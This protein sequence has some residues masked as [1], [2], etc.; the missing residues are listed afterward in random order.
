MFNKFRKSL[1]LRSIVILCTILSSIL[2][3]ITVTNIVHQ[4][5]TLWNRKINEAE[6]VSNV[7]LTA[8]RHPML[9]GDQDI[10]QLQFDNYKNLKEVEKIYL[11]DGYGVVKRSTDRHVLGTRFADRKTASALGGQPSFG[12]EKRKTGGEEFFSRIVPIANEQKCYGCHGKE[13]KVLGALGIEFDW[14]PVLR[15]AR[16]TRNDN[17]VLSLLGLF[18]MTVLTLLFLLKVIIQPIKKLEM[19]MIRVSQ[20]NFAQKIETAS[21]DEIGTLTRLFNRMAGD[22][23][24]FM[25]KEKYLI[26]A[27]QQ[28][29][30]ELARVNDNL[31]AEAKERKLVEEKLRT[32]SRQLL[33]IIDFLPDPTLVVNRERVVIAWNRA[34]EKFTDICKEDM[35]GKGKYYYAV[36]FYGEKR[37]MLVDLLFDDDKTVESKYD[38]FERKGNTLYAETT[39]PMLNAGKGLY[40]WI[41]ASSLFDSNGDFAGAVE[42]VRDISERKQAEEKLREAM[43]TKSKFISVVS[44]E[45]RTPLTSI[46]EGI[47]IVLDGSAGEV[48]DEQKD[49]LATAKRNVDRLARLINDVL[50]FQ[51]LESGKGQFT[52]QENALNDVVNEVYQSMSPAVKAK[53]L[54]FFITCDQTAGKLRFDRDKIIQVLTNLVNNAMKFTE[55]GSVTITTSRM[56]N[57]VYVCVEDTGPGMKQEEL[58]KLFQSFQ[59]FGDE[60]VRKGGSGLGLAISREIVEKHFGKIWAES[61]FGKGSKFI[62]TLPLSTLEEALRTIV[63]RDFEKQSGSGLFLLSVF[64]FENYQEVKTT[65]GQEKVDSAVRSIRD[66][67]ESVAGTKEYIC[68]NGQDEII[69][70]IHSSRERVA[71]E[72]QKLRR[73]VKEAVFDLD[74]GVGI[75]VSAASVVYPDEADTVKDALAQA[76]ASLADEPK[77]RLEKNILIVDDEEGMVKILGGLLKESGFKNITEACDGYEAFEKIKEMIPDIILLDMSM[78]RMNGYEVIGR[79]KGD[80]KT[81]EIPLLIMSGFEVQLDKLGGYFQKQAIPMISKPFDMQQLDKWLRYLV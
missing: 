73:A 49:F 40:V 15:E 6:S 57:W 56:K 62:F 52:V 79:L 10:I 27:E 8:L 4:K 37:P 47:N 34:M 45:L 23:S 75:R 11:L 78:P 39:A 24:L 80:V 22:L 61:V 30:E 68:E 76:E 35:I 58:D 41:T 77:H 55:K 36:P 7:V 9:V 72:R 5:R 50:D 17:I 33:D 21:S 12:M 1:A 43:A 18:M 69:V 19:G 25:E 64:R 71:E 16:L 42:S 81:K 67:I 3:F 20:G 28:R 54:D 51:K 46:K 32:A 14:K 2:A 63:E 70:F 48:N 59:Q 29:G 60:R 31:T 13:K 53:G 65:L 26:A 38:L 66:A 44:H 74:A